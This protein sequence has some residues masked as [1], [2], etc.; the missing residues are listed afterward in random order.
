MDYRFE[1]NKNNYEDF[2]SGR[3]LWNRQGT[4]SF[5]VRLGSEVLQRCMALLESKGLT[6]PYTLYDPCCGGAYLLTVLGVLHGSKLSR[7]YASD[8]DEQAV[9]LAQKNLSLLTAE[10]LEARVRQL[11]EYAAAYQKDSHQGALESAYRW[12]QTLESH[13]LTP[14]THCFCEDIL[15][16]TGITQPISA[17]LDMVITDVPYGNLV[18]WSGSLAS[19]NPMET[20]LNNLLP[21]LHPHSVIAVVADKKQ[22]IRHPHYRRREHCKVGHRQIAWL[23]PVL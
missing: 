12:K 14:T 4:T 9:Q 21:L 19:G 8:V 18:Q 11:Q 10:G 13:S 5:P 2:S 6:G 7:I 23:E 16:G 17:P 3:V 1:T 20:L 22:P 15:S